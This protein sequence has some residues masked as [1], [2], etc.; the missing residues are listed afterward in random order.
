MSDLPA[1]PN[2]LSIPSNS[3][4]AQ[5]GQ[6]RTKILNHKHFE[7]EEYKQPFS[8]DFYNLV[9]FVQNGNFHLIGA[10]EKINWHALPINVMQTKAQTIT[11]CFKE[12]CREFN[13]I[14]ELK[15]NLA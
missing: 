5:F 7:P 13:N 9:A 3:S 1:Q 6:L 2:D 11:D 12:A 4:L 8:F 15:K 14:E 10:P